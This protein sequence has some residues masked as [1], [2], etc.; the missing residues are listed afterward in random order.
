MPHVR[1]LTEADH[2]QAAANGSATDASALGYD[3]FTMS[4][5]AQS[6]QTAQFNPYAEE[7]NNMATTGTFPFSAQSA[8][9]APLQPLPYHLY[10]PV[11]TT[12]ENILPYQRQIQDFFLP[13]N[14][15]EDLQKK[16]EA[17]RQVLPG[18]SRVLGT[19]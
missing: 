4:N 1:P 15:R 9:Q 11:T 8:Y 13:D 12:R 7:H 19:L 2:L 6:L 10:N 18:K 3:P 17:A 14:L 16:S 5:V